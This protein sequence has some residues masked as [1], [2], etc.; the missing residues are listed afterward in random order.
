M[1]EDQQQFMRLLGQLPAR[2]TAE[3]AAWVL[4]CQPH[5]V[6]ILVGVRLLKPLGNP[7]PQSVKYFAASEL[8]EQVK[9]R[10][11]LAKVTNALNQHWQKRNAAKQSCSGNGSQN[12]HVVSV[13]Q[14]SAVNA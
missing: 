8:L 12:G 3:Q 1:R 4:N 13:G 7:P 6:P 5:D 9:D 2:L 11:W 10:M 14:S